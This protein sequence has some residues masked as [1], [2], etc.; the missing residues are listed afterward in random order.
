MA[1]FS[2]VN[3][4]F[5]M[6]ISAFTEFNVNYMFFTAYSSFC[7]VR[8]SFASF[9]FSKLAFNSHLVLYYSKSISYLYTPGKVPLT[10]LLIFLEMVSVNSFTMSIYNRLKLTST[11]STR[12]SRPKSIETSLAWDAFIYCSS[13]STSI[14]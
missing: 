6:S 11:C 4:L 10:S 13:Y 3:Y 9:S 12:C 14:N 7:F 1:N 5:I 2:R 8:E